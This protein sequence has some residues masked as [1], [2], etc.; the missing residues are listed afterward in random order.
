VGSRVGG[1]QEVI[2]SENCFELGDNFIDESSKRV[3]YFLE[4]GMRNTK[5]NI[6]FDLKANSIMEGNIYSDILLKNLNK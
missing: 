4:K 2:G 6:K 1:T 5:Q 3:V